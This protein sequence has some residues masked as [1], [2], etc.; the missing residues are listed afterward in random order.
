MAKPLGVVLNFY[1]DSKDAV[2]DNRK[3]TREGEGVGGKAKAAGGKLGTMAKV[4]VAGVAAGAATAA[5]ALFDMAK[6][7]QEDA[8][9]I[10]QLDR[11]LERTTDATEAQEF[12]KRAEA[13]LAQWFHDKTGLWVHGEQAWCTHPSKP[14]MR[15]TIDQYRYRLTV[16]VS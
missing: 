9:Q 11:I 15:C 8:K 1:A 4:G 3:L 2:K 10:A 16:Q 14:W 5:V 7:A 13:M 12:G 6:G